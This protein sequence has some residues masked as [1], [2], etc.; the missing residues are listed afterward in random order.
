M[1]EVVVSRILHEVLTLLINGIIGQMHA[2]IVKVA[3][4]GCNVILSSKPRQAFVINIDA[5]WNDASDQHIYAK[6]E[7]QI[8]DE[9]RLMKITLRHVVLAR[10]KPFPVPSQE[11]SLALTSRL[12]FNNKSLRLPIVELLFERLYILWEEKSIWKEA[13]VFWKVL[14][15]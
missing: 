15:H 6:V 7:L 5:K 10:L 14:L 1:A 3:A 11:D 13:K 2:Q 9:K 4:D 12:W 8:V